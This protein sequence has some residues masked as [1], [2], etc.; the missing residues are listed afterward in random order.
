MVRKFGEWT[1][2]VVAEFGGLD[3][4]RASFE[5]AISLMAGKHELK[6]FGQDFDGA[7]HNNLS[8]VT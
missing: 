5:K 1:P 2:S 3:E 8:V 6:R 7:A 4:N